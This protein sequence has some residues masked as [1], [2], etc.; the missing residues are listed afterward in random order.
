MPCNAYFLTWSVY[1]M[2]F[3]FDIISLRKLKTRSPPSLT[4]ETCVCV[5]STIRKIFALE[6]FCALKLFLRKSGI[7]TIIPINTFHP[8][9]TAKEAVAMFHYYRNNKSQYTKHLQVSHKVLMGFVFWLPHFTGLIDVWR[10]Y[11]GGR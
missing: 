5:C 7:L 11:M 1:D 3:H 6:H 4:L 9:L 10:L 2:D 8:S